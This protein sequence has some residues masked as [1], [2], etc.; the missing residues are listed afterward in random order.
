[1]RLYCTFIVSCSIVVSTALFG[2]KESYNWYFGIKAGI[3]FNPSG[4]PTALTNSSMSSGKGCASISD[5]CSG[6]LHF[7]TNGDSIFNRNHQTMLN[8]TNLD[9]SSGSTQS[10][11]IVPAPDTASGEYYVFTVERLN[12]LKYSVVNMNLA[13]GLGA[14]VQGKKNIPLISPTVEK[15]TAVKHR[16]GKRVWIITHKL[17]SDEFYS[18]L[19]SSN[20][21]SGNPVIS[22]TGQVYG[23]GS[24][25]GYMKA[26]P[27][28]NKIALA[29]N[30]DRKFELFDFDNST[31]IVS[32]PISTASI[33]NFAYGVEF[34]PDG[35]KL[36]FSS[37][38]GLFQY[39]LNTALPGKPMGDSV[40]LG[41]LPKVAIQLG[42]DG[43]IYCNEGFFLGTVNKPNLPGLQC[44]YTAGSV[45]LTNRF[46]SSGLPTFMQSYFSPMA[47]IE[48]GICLGLTTQFRII[49]ERSLDSIF[50]DFGD[51]GS[52]QLNNST[53][54]N[55]SHLYNTAGTYNVT[56]Y[57]SSKKCN[58]IEI[59]TI[60]KTIEILSLP[61]PLVDLG[62]D[63]SICQGTSIT[64]STSGIEPSYVWNTGSLGSSI[65]VTDEGTYWVKASNLCGSLSDSIEITFFTSEMQIDLGRDTSFCSGS[66]IKL[67]AGKGADSYLWNQGSE[68]DAIVVENEGFYWVRAL[69]KCSILTDTVFIE[70]LV[71]P[72]INL[73]MDT[74]ICDGINL[75]LT[76]EYP[77]SDYF[78][79][80]SSEEAS[81]SVNEEGSYRV[82]VTN[83]CGSTTD[84]IYVR[85][86]DCKCYVFV[87]NSFTPN[88]DGL[89]DI[90][91]L[92]Y[93]CE[94]KDFSFEIYNRWGELVYKSLRPDFKWIYT[95]N[96]SG[97][98]NY[99][100]K[101]TSTDPGDTEEHIERGMLNLIK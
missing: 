42:P 34:S 55:T 67:N 3:T 57:I 14:L 7:Y 63:T 87:P 45:N 2:Q 39:N 88:S 8:G 50:W 97:V 12:G 83:N 16:D 6:Q 95:G 40:Q 73:G 76:A 98:Y 44:N 29:L 94:F 27:L 66:S 25:L 1:M 78:W 58:Q 5:S 53:S 46:A 81:I 10:A 24:Q 92:T 38:L 59:D 18:F 96:S 64:L 20:G 68:S 32:N 47:I 71:R 35:S 65:D 89:N 4:N 26:S 11:I 61:I 51:P 72:S 17:N 48:D 19:L 69:D 9:G 41:T 60:V 49:G 79:N 91:E 15:V 23:T 37:D 77:E 21:I 30:G 74:L 75:E 54:F 13:G 62:N 101:Y 82:K 33:Y 36:Y 85:V 43:I 90:L 80:D 86:K 28:G 84:E 22:T 56:A 52:G 31:G 70:E 93:S 100:L 99:T